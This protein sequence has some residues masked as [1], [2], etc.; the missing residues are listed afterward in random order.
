MTPHLA[1]DQIDAAL[2]VLRSRYAVAGGAEN[3]RDQI[4][5]FATATINAL[6]ALTA[7][8]GEDTDPAYIAREAE[9]FCQSVEAAFMDAVE[10]EDASEP[11]INPAAQ[12]G[13]YSTLGGHVNG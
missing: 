4:S 6:A 3:R 9:G 7:A 11:R 2:S 1:L 8:Y 10:A 13:T 12:W 5:E